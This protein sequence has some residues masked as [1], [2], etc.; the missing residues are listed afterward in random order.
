VSIL[1]DPSQL[2]LI[3]GVD[4]NTLPSIVRVLLLDGKVKIPT[5]RYS[6]PHVELTGSEI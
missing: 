2:R 4:V 1:L 3:A 5:L 6:V